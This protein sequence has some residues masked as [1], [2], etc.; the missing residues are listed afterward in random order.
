MRIARPR[1]GEFVFQDLKLKE[2]LLR[3]RH[4]AL[5]CAD[6]DRIATP[7]NGHL[8]LVVVGQGV[9]LG[10]SKLR[11]EAI[12]EKKPP[13]ETEAPTGGPA[14][15]F[16]RLFVF[17]FGADDPPS[18]ADALRYHDVEALAAL[19]RKYSSDPIP[20]R[21]FV[22]ALFRVADDVGDV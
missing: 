3:E 22:A 14:A 9:L 18:D 5:A 2:I 15:L 11:V 13:A 16:G 4:A 21:F 6:A 12:E 1:I 19:V 10:L 7:G 8:K 20:D 17:R